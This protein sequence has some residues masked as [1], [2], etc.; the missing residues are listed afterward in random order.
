MCE[1]FSGLRENTWGRCCLLDEAPRRKIC[2]SSF[3]WSLPGAVPASNIA[4][5]GLHAKRRKSNNIGGPSDRGKP[6][7]P[8]G[9]ASQKWTHI[10]GSSAKDHCR[11]P[12]LL[13]FGS[14]SEAS[15][16]SQ[17]SKHGSS[18]DWKPY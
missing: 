18:A 9:L 7:R 2:P 10:K 3:P 5:E 1:P 15:C 8:L 17:R 12:E 11:S 6:S 16:T 14:Y 4:A 13:R